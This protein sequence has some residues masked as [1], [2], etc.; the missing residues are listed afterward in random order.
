MLARRAFVTLRKLFELGELHGRQVAKDLLSFL[1]LDDIAHMFSTN[2]IFPLAGNFFSCFLRSMSKGILA[3]DPGEKE[4]AYVIWDGSSILA[5]EILPNE[6][7]LKVLSVHISSPHA[8]SGVAIERVASYGMAVGR[9]VFETCFMIGRIWQ[10]II[11]ETPFDTTLPIAL[12]PRVAVKRAICHDSRAKDANL[13][14]AIKDRFGKGKT[15]KG[16]KKDPSVLY[17]IN[18]HLWAALALAVAVIDDPRL[19]S[20]HSAEL[21]SQSINRPATSKSEK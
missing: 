18:T 1:W 6:R 8:F 17:G 15:G 11:N 16:T 10:T 12:I 2:I 14:Q 5:K 9:E 4:S 13:S 7:F 19:M 20:E 3:I 21:L